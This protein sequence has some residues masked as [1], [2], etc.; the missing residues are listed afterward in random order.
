MIEVSTRKRAV[1]TPFFVKKKGDRIR[2]I[3]DA[4]AVNQHFTVPDKPELSSAA[5]MSE[6]EVPAD[7]TLYWATSDLKDAFYSMKI[8]AWLGE[9]FCLPPV[10]VEEA[11]EVGLI[12]GQWTGRD[13]IWPRLSVLAM[14]W[15]WS[16]YFCQ[17]AHET[18][19]LKS[20]LVS[21]SQKICE[22]RPAPPVTAGALA[23]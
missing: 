22:H 4:R 1:V 19:L 20:G 7:S 17:R 14:G 3:L 13:K 16:V 5:A 6:I 15:S 8:P 2:L 12:T 18:I 23:W 11:R 9:Y 10:T 21:R